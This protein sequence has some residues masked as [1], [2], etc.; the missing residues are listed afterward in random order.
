MSDEENKDAKEAARIVAIAKIVTASLVAKGKVDAATKLS[1]TEVDDIV[2]QLCDKFE[3]RLYNNIG[4]GVL[5]FIWKGVILGV[6]AIAA[7]GAG[8][9]FWKP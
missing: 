1:D 4:R 9:H 3:K 8:V 7:Y 2:E 5:G 6:L